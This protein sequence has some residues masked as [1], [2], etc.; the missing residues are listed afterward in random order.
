MSIPDL[1]IIV[2][3]CNVEKYLIEAIESLIGQTLKNIEILLIN[4]GSTDTSGTICEKYAK[5]DKRI[6]YIDQ[7]NKGYGFTCNVGIKQS[8]GNYITI[9]E[10]DDFIKKNAYKSLYDKAVKNNVDI[11][12]FGFCLLEN[13]TES[14]SLYLNHIKNLLLPVNTVFNPLDYPDMFTYQPTVWGFLY[15]RSFIVDNT[16][17]FNETPGA[18][19]QDNTFYFKVFALAASMIIDDGIY[20]YYRQHPEQ[21][22]HNKSKVNAPLYEMKTIRDFLN[23]RFKDHDEK[24]YRA[25]YRQFVNRTLDYFNL[26]FRRLDTELKRHFFHSYV[27]FFKETIAMHRDKDFFYSNLNRNRKRIYDAINRNTIYEDFLLAE[28]YFYSKGEL[29]R[30]AK[31]SIYAQR[32]TIQRLT[33]AYENYFFGY[34]D[35]PAMDREEKSHLALHA[36]FMDHL[37]GP[38]DRARLCLVKDDGSI[39]IFGETAAWCFQQGNLLQFLPGKKNQVIYN[40]FNDKAGEFRSVVHDLSSGVKKELPLPVACVS[41]DGTK[42]LSI[43]FARLYDYRPGYGYCNIRDPYADV[44][45]PEEDG[46]FILEIETGTSELVLSYKKLWELYAKDTA[47]ENCKILINHINFN[48]D[49]SRFI[50]LL[51]FFSESPPLPTYTVTADIRGGTITKIFGFGSHYH[52]KDKN[53][54]ALSGQNIFERKDLKRMTLY[55]IEDKTGTHREVDCDFFIGDGHCSYSPDRRYLLYDSYTSMEFP[56]RKLQIYDVEQKK[57]ITLG[58]FLSDPELYNGID[59]CRCDLHPRWSPCGSYI[60]FD[61]IHEGFRGIY[62]IESAEAIRELN[63]NIAELSREDIARIVSHVP[64][65]AMSTPL[66]EYPLKMLFLATGEKMSRRLGIFNILKPFVDIIRRKR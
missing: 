50:F 2:P 19:Y 33:P 30:L 49:G 4:D 27:D 13:G 56:Y 20:Y 47:V 52:W 40:V 28:G 48:T 45:C 63:R 25:L 65:E 58:Y 22:V 23:D 59:D 46:V 35:I 57:G 11:I 3:V 17:L 34:F 61:S 31:K 60:T 39:D 37:P 26:H 18:S 1:S 21:S 32:A 55:E 51:R 53:T 10:P 64:Q 15:K 29:Q 36:P 43:N 66:E 6:R 44:I 5:K 41:P 42:A 9:L 54:L 62:R 12:R 24:A 7:E 16:I 38:E 8:T 14:E